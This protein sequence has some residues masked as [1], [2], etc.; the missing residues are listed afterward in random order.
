MKKFDKVAIIGISGRFPG[1]SSLN[2]LDRIYSNKIDCVKPFSEK[3]RDLL[4]LDKTKKYFEVAYLDEVEYFDYDFFKISRQEASCMDP[5]QKMVLELA[6]EAIEDAGYSLNSARGSKTSVILGAHNSH[7]FDDYL[8]DG[9]GFAQIGNFLDTL[10]GRIA[11]CLDLHGQA[12]IVETACSSSLYAIYEA[13]LRLNAEEADMVLAGGI[14]LEFRA[15]YD[16]Y[17]KTDILGLISP[18]ARC[19]TFDESADGINLGEG[20]GFVLLKRY[21][22]A[23]R[24]KDSIHAVI[25]SVAA[26]QDGGRSNSL[27]APSSAAQCEV[28]LN[29][30]E[31]A[32]INP[33]DIGYFEAHGTGTKIGDPIEI[34]G[35]TEAFKKYTDKKQFCPIGSLKTNLSHLGSAAG[36]SSVLKGVISFKNNKKYPLCNLEKTN[37]LIDFKNSPVYPIT[38]V[39]SWDEKK[40]KIMVMSGFGVSGTNV[41]LV[42][43]D[44]KIQF[45][46]ADDESEYLVTISGKTSETIDS[47]KKKLKENV[48]D[49]SLGDIC[50]TL[51]IGRNDYKFRTSAK[52]RNKKEFLDFLNIKTDVSEIEENKLIFL[53]S[54]DSL[55]S[56]QE[57]NELKEKYPVFRKVY[58]D[59]V[60]QSSV[61]NE[62]M[63]KAISYIAIYNQLTEWGIVPDKIIGTGLGNIVIDYIT[64][65]ITLSEA[66]KEIRNSKYNEFNQSGFENYIESFNQSEKNNIVLVE[67]G[68]YGKMSNCLKSSDR[69]KSLKIFTICS[70]DISFLD[71]ISSM[72][73]VGVNI[74][75]N[76]YYS[77]KENVKVHIATYPFRKTL[78]WSKSIKCREENK[79]TEIEIDKSLELKE[80]LKNLW[81]N[82]LDI[83]DIDDNEDFFDLG[84]NS[85]MTM[86]IISIIS[87][88]TGIELDF[89]DFYEYATINDLE[90]YI[91]SKF[92][93]NEHTG[94][95]KKDMS[96]EITRLERKELMK[97]SYNQRRML[98][99]LETVDNASLYN[100]PFIFK[101][102]GNLNKEAF[103]YSLKQ[104]IERHE[105]FH[106]IYEKKD[107]EYYQKIL[108]EY[109]FEPKFEDKRGTSAQ[110]IIN[111]LKNSI[112]YK[113]DLFN[114][115]P[116]YSE[117]VQ[118]S[119]DSYF[120]LINMHHIVADGSSLAIFN[121]DLS[122]YYSQYIKGNTDFKIP[123]LKIQYA[124]FA[125]WENSFLSSEKAKKQLDFWK[126]E[127]QNVEGILNFP[128]DK[129]RPSVQT[130]NGKV[131]EFQLDEE[132][133]SMCKTY[134]RN[135]NLSLYMLLE[136]IYAIELYRYSNN[137]DICVGSPVS[138]RGDE[139][140]KEMIGFF[141]NTIVI[142]NKINPEEPFKETV[143]RN[144]D[145]ISKIYS[146]IEL[147]YEEVI[148]NVDFKRNLAYSP[149]IQYMFAFQNFNGIEFE[150]N[151]LKIKFVS[152]DTSSSKFEMTMML[153][154]NEN[155]I[156]GIVEYNTDLF[157]QSTINKF[158]DTYKFMIKYILNNDEI[159][160]N[161]ILLGEQDETDYIDNRDK[162]EDY[163]F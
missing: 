108:N 29:A 145:N 104:V 71:A 132:L 158:I 16:D 142:R 87:K 25:R 119:D 35:I 134:C 126:T 68:K 83:D 67:L 151:D 70:N 128:I 32:D 26:N 51:N 146:N 33:E 139:N 19:R 152:L 120:W 121:R 15:K 101:I 20:A 118:E 39:E 95:I 23:I 77:T 12:A 113:F 2:D 133:A 111:D 138:N 49:Y 137:N 17:A 102:E 74:D 150:L 58:E 79:K 156:S 153:Y 97:A 112:N 60:N 34:L 88:R 161:N 106:T 24:D 6:C 62:D 159:T 61:N 98:Y 99:I 107:G 57:V 163:S 56:Q 63:L 73:N 72:Y 46:K 82:E 65:K 42:L 81:C 21:E 55:F 4:K 59:L 76:K 11:Y 144:K 86:N 124:D 129:E 93:V 114:E 40:P 3:R 37:S 27:A 136:T 123:E 7:F 155:S 94:E 22:D 148:S 84:A 127:L 90:E 47:Y 105:I 149:L 9:S 13:C 85:L 75:W 91:K 117:L 122:L 53:I 154:E 66:E 69:F 160:V 147:P 45:D 100:M 110:D 10:A 141:A 135:N 50:Y 48:N 28:L 18:Q 157:N 80:F 116:I 1:A 143:Q 38:E 5:Q 31:K 103:I 64:N 36:I 89:N 96:N 162:I 78:A 140:T 44:N 8:E 115:I 30:W 52:V 43:E 14:T 41:H 131:V 109:T 130:F 125:E 92:E 54:G